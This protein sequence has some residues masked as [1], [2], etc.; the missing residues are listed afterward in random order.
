[1]NLKESNTVAELKAEINVFSL[2]NTS[3]GQKTYNLS[4]ELQ[5][6]ITDWREVTNDELT[7]AEAGFVKKSKVTVA[8]RRS[9]SENPE[10]I[11]TIRLE[12]EGSTY[13]ISTH[14]DQEFT[15]LVCQFFKVSCM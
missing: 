14:K 13:T 12:Y 9:H 1:M 2:P 6:I 11:V 3:N 15:V 8:M 7:L 10:N 5:L 4:E